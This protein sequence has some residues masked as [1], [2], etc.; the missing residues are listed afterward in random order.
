MRE[1]NFGRTLLEM[2]GV[3]SIM[4]LLTVG[5]FSLYGRSVAKMRLN[6]L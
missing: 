6:N 3:I 1:N 5:G 4:G 2:I